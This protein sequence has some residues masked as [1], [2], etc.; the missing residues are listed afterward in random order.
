M[1]RSENII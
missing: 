1:N